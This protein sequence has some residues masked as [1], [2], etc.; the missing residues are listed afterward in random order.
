MYASARSVATVS[1]AMAALALGC[2]DAGAPAGPSGRIAVEVAPLDLEQVSIACYDVLVANADGPVWRRGDPATTRREGDSE[3]ICSDRFG[4]PDGDIAY[5][6]SCDADPG[7]DTDSEREGTQNEV[8]LWVDGLYDA[9]VTR[10]LGDWQDPCPDGCTLVATCAENADTPVVFDLTI[11]RQANQGF[12]DIAVNFSDVFCSAKLDTCYTDGRHIELI[13]GGDS[14][15]DW[16]AVFG[17]ACSPGSDAVQSNILYGPVEVSCGDISF[18]V[19]PTQEGNSVAYG[20]GGVELNYAVYRGEELLDCGGGPGSCKKIYWNLAFSLEDLAALGAGTSCK[21]TL[22]A[23]AND[24]DDDFS[25]GLP[26]AEGLAYPYIVVDAPLTDDGAAWC[27][28]NPLATSGPVRVEYRGDVGGLTAPIPMCSEYDGALTTTGAPG[29]DG[30]AS[31]CDDGDPCTVDACSF[32]SCT[33]E[34]MDCDDSDPCT[35]DACVEGTCESNPTCVN[36]VDDSLPDPLAVDYANP[37]A[38]LLLAND[39][40]PDELPEPLAIV[41]VTMTSTPAGGEGSTVEVVDGEVLFTPTVPGSYGFAYT[42]SDGLTSDGASVSLT[43]EDLIVV[44]PAAGTPTEFPNDSNSNVTL[45]VYPLT[46]NGFDAYV[47]DSS[48]DELFP[49]YAAS[50]NCD[51]GAHTCTLQLRVDYLFEPPVGTV[52]LTISFYDYDG[53]RPSLDFVFEATF[54]VINKPPVANPDSALGFPNELL[55]MSGPGGLLQNDSDPNA[56]QQPFLVEPVTVLSRPVGSD[57]SAARVGD[58]IEFTGSRPGDYVLEYTISDGEL[59]ATST[60]DVRLAPGRDLYVATIPNLTAQ[61]GSEGRLPLAD[62]GVVAVYNYPTPHFTRLDPDAQVV[63]QTYSV[64]DMTPFVEDIELAGTGYIAV[65][66]DRSVGGNTMFATVRYLDASGIMQWVHRI[67][68]GVQATQEQDFW[69]AIAPTGTGDFVMA[70]AADSLTPDAQDD[71]MIGRIGANGTYAWVRAIGTSGVNERY[72]D[73][74]VLTGGQVVAVGARASGSSSD[75]F[76]TGVD[77][78]GNH[79]FTRSFGLTGSNDE[80]VVGNVAATPDGGFVI[81]GVYRFTSGAYPTTEFIAK[82]DASGNR[83]WGRNL[84]V[85]SNGSY[86]KL[87]VTPA[88]GGGYFVTNGDCCPKET[89][90]LKLDATGQVL[91][92]RRLTGHAGGGV[93]ATL[94]EMSDGRLLIVT[95]GRSIVRLAP[96]GTCGA[97]CDLI[98]TITVTT[99]SRTDTMNTVT[100]TVS[101][102]T[103]SPVAMSLTSEVVNPQPTPKFECADEWPEP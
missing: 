11:L 83:E 65:G 85:G 80:E 56:G 9:G 38:A 21:L 63:F 10:D 44:V 33:N 53:V 70:G 29:C 32:G 3:A 12:V 22:E 66:N 94:K 58:T 36:A 35:L 79:L 23:T 61:Y 82:F 98:T 55:V 97:D 39:G 27:Q 69:R 52:A 95:D 47:S 48:D 75:G 71:G 6:G 84:P 30:C 88:A 41:S 19:D 7:A 13:H 26:S 67:G 40:D 25:G 91:W 76:I 18:L 2:A 31:D 100:P 24:D 72:H 103:P 5:V 54:M 89:K 93:S 87:F 28:R 4:S 59:T 77:G 90:L 20:P 49:S 60:I 81:G 64:G 99:T 57:A 74:A 42:L 92:A 34:P 73:V 14:V 16:T 43:A 102:I 17:L 46:M 68:T 51:S 78:D 8:T 50:I 1:A 15:R 45:E 86:G 62:G 101:T 37:I 96:D